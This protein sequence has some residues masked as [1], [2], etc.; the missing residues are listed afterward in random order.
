MRAAAKSDRVPVLG[1]L[2][3]RLVPSTFNEFPLPDL[4]RPHFGTDLILLD[5]ITAGPDGN[6]WFT[7]TDAGAIGSITPS[8]SFAEFVQLAVGRCREANPRRNESR[9]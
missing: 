7:D 9:P 1:E 4:P 5:G 3:R 8:G 6:V 2:E